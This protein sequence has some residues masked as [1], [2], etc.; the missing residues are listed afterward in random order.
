MAA[1]PGA[2]YERYDDPQSEP[3]ICI[4]PDCDNQLSNGTGVIVTYPKSAGPIRPLTGWLCT[5]CAKLLLKS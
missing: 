2:K 5:A 1:K 4:N 3:T